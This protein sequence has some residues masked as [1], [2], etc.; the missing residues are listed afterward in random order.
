MTNQIS[1]KGDLA[2]R[3]VW[4]PQVE[5]FFD[6]RIVD[7]DAPSYSSMTLQS[8]LRKSEKEK[9]TKYMPAC[10]ERHATFTPLLTT[11]GGF[12]GV[13]FNNF[14][15]IL[16]DKLADR[17]QKPYSVIMSWVRV[18]LTYAIPEHRACV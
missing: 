10:E 4:D 8:V 14:L 17:W 12:F 1:L 5:A 2:C 6:I 9:K 7:A 3:G 15:K 11:T 18:R 13:E 16:A